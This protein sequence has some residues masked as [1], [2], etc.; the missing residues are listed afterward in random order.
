[1]RGS[2]GDEDMRK[3][4]NL[5][6]NAVFSEMVCKLSVNAINLMDIKSLS[7]V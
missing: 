7:P 5:S 2:E 4:E 3:R 1:M 6:R